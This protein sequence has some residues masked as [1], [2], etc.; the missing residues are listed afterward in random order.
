[1]G[2]CSMCPTSIDVSVA[3]LLMDGYPIC[4]EC[5][6]RIDMLLA[7]KVSGKARDSYTYNYLDRCAQSA[8]NKEVADYLHELLK[9]E[10]TAA[11]LAANGPPPSYPP[12]QKQ[13]FTPVR[14]AKPT[15]S[16]T[17]PKRESSS[18]SFWIL[19]M[20]IAAWVMFAAI[21]I[22][23]IVVGIAYDDAGTALLII[24]GSI[25]GAFVSVAFI[26]IFLDMAEDI[27]QIRSNTSKR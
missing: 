9:K 1:V 25:V 12:P 19:I 6:K 21:I 23:G 11:P 5:K 27:K 7:N 2:T 15:K 24:F 13:F 17:P 10:E 18:S 4:A 16:S 8:K 3:A 20:R 14:S 22:S 26:M